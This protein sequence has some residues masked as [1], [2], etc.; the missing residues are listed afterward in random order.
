[1]LRSRAAQFSADAQFS[2]AAA[3]VAVPAPVVRGIHPVR[4][5]T[6]LGAVP[7]TPPVSSLADRRDRADAQVL[8]PRVRA[9][10]RV[11]A[12]AD[13]LALELVQAVE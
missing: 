12:L 10:V 8:E 6:A 2:T 3:P 1:M 5:R 4:L 11:R 13:R 9:S 7:C